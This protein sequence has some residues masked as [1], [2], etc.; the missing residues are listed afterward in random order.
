MDII[1][2]RSEAALKMAV[3]SQEGLL[4]K[5]ITLNRKILLDLIVNLE[6]MIDYPEDDVEE[7][8]YKQTMEALER[9]Q[10]IL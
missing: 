3:R 10:L 8:T 1:K 6:A 5:Q 7:V 4:S 2:S 9:S